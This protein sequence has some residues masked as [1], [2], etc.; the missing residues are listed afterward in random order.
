MASE[1]WDASVLSRTNVQFF[2]SLFAAASRCPKAAQYCES[3]VILDEVNWSA[4]SAVTL[5]CRHQ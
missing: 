2:E 1:N 5:L 4:E 3:V